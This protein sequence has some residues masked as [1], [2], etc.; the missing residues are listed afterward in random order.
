MKILVKTIGFT[1]LKADVEEYDVGI[2]NVIWLKS[3]NYRIIE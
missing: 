2:P 1:N 3:N